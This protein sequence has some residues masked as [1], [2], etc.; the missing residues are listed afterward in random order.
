MKKKEKPLEYSI[1]SDADMQQKY[2]A[3]TFTTFSL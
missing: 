1:T 3:N 2:P